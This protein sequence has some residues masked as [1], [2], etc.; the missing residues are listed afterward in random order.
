MSCGVV[1]RPVAVFEGG[2]TALQN[3]RAMASFMSV[4]SP[5]KTPSMGGSG[6]ALG[7]H[8]RVPH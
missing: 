2:G 3:E 6:S 8:F 5:Q 7:E 1:G 4:A